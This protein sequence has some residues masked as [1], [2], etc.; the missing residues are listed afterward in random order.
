MESSI[1][2]PAAETAS[3]L[4]APLASSS[5]LPK[6]LG[7]VL[8]ALLLILPLILAFVQLLRRQ[9]Q[10]DAVEVPLTPLPVETPEAG[11]VEM[12]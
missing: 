2:P 1:D 12:P 4:P 5:Q 11:D 9:Q 8:L 10:E 3:A 6:N 7:I